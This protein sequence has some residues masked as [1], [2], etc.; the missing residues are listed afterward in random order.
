MLYG[1]IPSLLGALTYILTI[2]YAILWF[3]PYLM[4]R[5]IAPK[6]NGFVSTL[7]FPAAVITVEFLNNL[8]FGSWAAT[9]YTQFDNLALIQI[10]SVFGMWGVSFIVMWFASVANWVIDNDLDWQITKS[11][12]GIYAIVLSLVLLYG[13]L[14]LEVWP[15]QSE[16]VTIASFTPANE[17][18]AY[19]EKMQKQGYSSS[20]EMAT[21]GRATQAILLDSIHDQIFERSKHNIDPLAKLTLW[22]EGTIRVLEENETAF[23]N[24]G[25]NWALEKN[26]YLLL[27]YS[28][29]P[30]E[31]PERLA[32][33]KAVLI[34]PDGEMEWEYL[35]AHPT[36]GSTDVAGDGIIP[37]TNTP[38]G[39]ISTTICYDM[40]FTALLHKA[41]KA[42]IDIMLVPAW[43]WKAID[44]LHA[45]M[46]TFRAIENGF[47]MVRQTGEGLSIAVDHQGRTLAA[48][49]HFTTAD[50]TM[51]S[52]VPIKGVK[53]VYAYIGDTFAWLCL[54]GLG[55]SIG[56]GIYSGRTSRHQA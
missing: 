12:A 19:V 44:P 39:K 21:T 51:K 54:I 13:G 45:R 3:F 11:G 9:A 38:F 53:T 7:V 40:D 28:M 17:I 47:S 18:E 48:M 26:G 4:D 5:W 25:K 49:D 36:P 29:L 1:I 32:E 6:L 15:P 24:K 37:I 50:Y 10:S 42:D 2:Y 22:P 30:I 8:F 23:I 33:N 20:I 56:W 14:R 55:L 27:G 35:K 34:N 43:D 46:A 52:S 41:G 31:N 16:T